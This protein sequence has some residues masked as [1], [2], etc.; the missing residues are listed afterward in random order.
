MLA[1]I[2]DIHLEKLDHLIPDFNAKVLASLKLAVESA[3]DKG[4]QDVVL[5]GDIFD[6]PYPSQESVV[7][8]LNTLALLTKQGVKI[9]L[10]LGNH[11]FASKGINSLT[12]TGWVGKFSTPDIEVVT[13]PKVITVD[14]YK[15]FI[16]PHTHVVDMPSGADFALGHFAINGS[17]ADNGFK[18]RSKHAP[19]GD[20]VM[21]DFHTAQRGVSSKCSYEYIGSLTQLSWFEKP[22]KSIVLV[23]GGDKSRIRLKPTYRLIRSVVASDSELPLC[24]EANSFYYLQTK[25]GYALPKGWLTEHPQVVRVSSVTQR[26]DKRAQVLLSEATASTNPL[27]HLETFLF[28]SKSLDKAVVH[29]AL[30][31]AQGIKV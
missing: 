18:V 5:L 21:A 16:C 23:D 17:R 20:W 7:S 2:G 19:T 1:C 15:Y 3:M 29:R 24:R 6:S 11:D 26:T 14:G 8:L 27:A 30:E 25:D 22:A 28:R 4:C 10:M 31:I 9:Y 13:K 12:T